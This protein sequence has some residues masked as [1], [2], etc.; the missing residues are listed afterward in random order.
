MRNKFFDHGFLFNFYIDRGS[1]AAHFSRSNVSWCGL[2][3][4]STETA[5]CSFRV[6]CN[7]DRPWNKNWKSGNSYFRNP[8]RVS[9]V[10]FKL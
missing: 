7:F 3:I 5:L 1:T 6:F 4:S 2:G 10:V 8:R 9:D